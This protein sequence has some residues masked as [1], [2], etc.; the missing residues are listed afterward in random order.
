MS[1]THEKVENTRVGVWKEL[2]N[3]GNFQLY[4]TNTMFVVRQRDSA[5]C[6]LETTERTQIMAL[7]LSIMTGDF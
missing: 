7:L 5:Y 2:Q 1:L 6:H 3:S 4:E